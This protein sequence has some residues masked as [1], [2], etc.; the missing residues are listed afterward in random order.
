MSIFLKQKSALLH[1][2]DKLHKRN[3]LSK[4]GSKYDPNWV[5]ELEFLEDMV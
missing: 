5:D 2:I 4:K 1:E 3:E